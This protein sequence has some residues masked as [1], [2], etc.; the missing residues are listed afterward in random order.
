MAH[1]YH[2]ITIRTFSDVSTVTTG[3]MMTLR[4][5]QK[6][7]VDGKESKQRRSSRDSTGRD[8]FQ[9]SKCKSLIFMYQPDRS[10]QQLGSVF[11]KKPRKK[12][13]G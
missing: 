8:G 1:S 11:V 7:R 13:F 3:Q 5:L 6:V 2:G 9:V 4:E 12:L 10:L